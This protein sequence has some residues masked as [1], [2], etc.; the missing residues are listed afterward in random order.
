MLLLMLMLC[1]LAGLV[2]CLMLLF[3]LWLWLL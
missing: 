1:R 2:D 3:W